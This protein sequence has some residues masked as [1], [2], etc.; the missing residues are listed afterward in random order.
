MKLKYCTFQTFLLATLF[1]QIYAENPTK[2]DS[3]NLPLFKKN[4]ALFNKLPHK[5]L[6]SFPTPIIK[7]EQLGRLLN[8]DNLYIK[9]DNLSGAKSTKDSTQLF[10]GNKVR[11]LEFLLADALNAG[12]KTILTIGA[13]GSNHALATA[14]YS[15]QL[16][17]DCIIM[18]TPQP[19]ASYV[20]RNLLMDLY[21]KPDIKAY[22]SDSQREVDIFN[23]SR[24]F[25]LKD[26]KTPYFIPSGGSNEIGAIGFVN[27]AFELKEQIDKGVLPE[28]DLIYVTAGSCGTASG[29]ILGSKAAGLKSKIVAVRISGTHESKVKSINKLISE[30]NEYLNKLDP[31]FPI[32]EI[33]E[34]DY[35]ISDDFAGEKYAE[36]TIE[37]AAAIKLLKLSENIQLDG[38]YTGKTF[39]ALLADLKKPET[40]NKIILFWN[41]YSSGD[42]EYVASD[43]NYLDLPVL[44][45]GYFKAPLQTLDQGC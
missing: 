15:K 4:P 40:K 24:K 13:A 37:A 19:N 1:F 2:D 10:G 35:I 6:G 29:L 26:Q 43:M 25:I 14:I 5:S 36:I 28:P 12:A 9:Q 16:D 7:L 27:A 17:L 34:N 23:T 32:F 38:T 31:S 41:T 45:Q 20:R 3:K 18:L 21:Y 44:L 8:F 22:A 33:T 42:F 11:K 39:S 30:T